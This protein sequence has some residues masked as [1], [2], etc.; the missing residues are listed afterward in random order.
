MSGV[1]ALYQRSPVWLQN[2]LL[3]LHASRILLHRYDRPYREAIAG[4]LAQEHW[5]RQRIQAAQLQKLQWV[6]CHAYE[7]SPYYRRAMN[8]GGVKPS[9]LRD[10]RD[11][12]RWPLLDKAIV[13]ERASELLTATK[14]RRGWL[15][16]HTSGTTGSPLG[17]WYDR[18]ACRINNAVDRQFKT[19]AGVGE[20]DW[21]G[22]LLGRVVVPIQS[23]RPPFWRV[24]RVHR[25]VWLSSFHLSDR[26][27][28]HYVREIER[29]RLRFL[30]G[31][32]S[33]LYVLAKFLLQQGRV[34]P[35]RAVISSSETL[36][37]LQREAIES[38]FQCKLYDFYALAERVIFAG[39]CG[40]GRG[41]HLAETYG[42]TEVVDEDGQPVPDGETGYLVGTS[43]HNT[44]MPMIRY[45]TGD[46]S[47]I[48][49]EP[50]PCGRTMRRIRD[51]STKAEDIVVT[52]DGRQISPSILTH[53]FKP[54]ENIEVSQIIQERVDHLLVKLVASGGFSKAEE[55]TLIASLRERLGE[56]MVIEVRHVAEIPREPSG[57]FRW[58]ISH[59]DH[60]CALT[61][62]DQP[63]GIDADE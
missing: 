34:L 30:E 50:C 3:N 12:S 40:H 6:V 23:T 28:E 7:R 14:P 52:A 2:L 53:P 5:D 45:R 20:T 33:T 42:L 44:A 31:Y 48:V 59:V 11:L 32:P 43:L 1:E 49:P 17:V 4:L 41:K 55:D 63:R 36:H 54:I 62:E 24:N 21:I 56:G 27:L 38:A 29:R 57:K 37:G 47:A 25:Q 39:E 35:M 16:G 18:D 61:W 46:V 9:D 13:R 15:H 10:I 19:W 26:Y 51:V 8:E 22:F 58:V 60:S